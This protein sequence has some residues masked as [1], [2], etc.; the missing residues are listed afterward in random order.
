MWFADGEL[1]SCADDTNRK[2]YTPT[3]ANVGN[4][5][6]V[7]HDHNENGCKDREVCCNAQ[8]MHAK[9]SCEPCLQFEMEIVGIDV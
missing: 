6:T 7:V 9:Q 3:I 4:V 5:L 2:C 1:V 8:Q